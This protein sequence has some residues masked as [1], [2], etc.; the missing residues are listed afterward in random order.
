M[1]KAILERKDVTNLMTYDQAPKASMRRK[2]SSMRS[3][4]ALYSATFGY[5]FNAIYYS[6]AQ[7]IQ[8][9]HLR[10]LLEEEEAKAHRHKSATGEFDEAIS[11]S[12]ALASLDF[13]KR[14]MSALLKELGSDLSKGLTTD[15]AKEKLAIYGPNKL[16]EP[17]VHPWYVRL[18][19]EFFT[20]MACVLWIGAILSY[21]GYALDREDPSNVF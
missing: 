21:V 8:N 10:T 4:V 14:E 13:H 1:A 17:E 15:Q 11:K 12:D 2:M 9:A 16:K 19:A 5:F 6:R 18:L 7:M 3:V 20:L